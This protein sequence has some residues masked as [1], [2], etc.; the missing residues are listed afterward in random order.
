MGNS[1][2]TGLAHGLRKLVRYE[3]SAAELLLQIAACAAHARP[4][5]RIFSI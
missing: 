2:S 1:I 4:Q 3:L 5:F